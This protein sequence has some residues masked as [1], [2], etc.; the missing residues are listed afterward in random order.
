MMRGESSPAAQAGNMQVGFPCFSVIAAVTFV[1]FGKMREAI[2]INSCCRHPVAL[3]RANAGQAAGLPCPSWPCP[4]FH[5]QEHDH[6]SPWVLQG[7][8][9]H[10]SELG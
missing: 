3:Q 7:N 9:Q 6:Q 1:R 5:G 8:P 2:L 10:P 4:I